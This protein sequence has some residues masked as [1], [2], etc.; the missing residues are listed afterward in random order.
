MNAVNTNTPQERSFFAVLRIGG[1]SDLAAIVVRSGEDVESCAGEMPTTQRQSL[2]GQL[3][4]RTRTTPGARGYAARDRSF[5]ASASN[6]TRVIG[7][8]R[9]ESD[10][11]CR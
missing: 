2:R 8:E 10:A 3:A 9:S 5:S 6:V 1:P 11:H 7:A 4:E